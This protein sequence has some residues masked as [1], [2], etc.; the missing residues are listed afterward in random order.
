[1]I[2]IFK[3]DT[4]KDGTGLSELA[5]TAAIS[6]VLT[7]AMKGYITDSFQV[8]DVTETY[9]GLVREE[10]KVFVPTPDEE[11]LTT[12]TSDPTPTTVTPKASMTGVSDDVESVQV[13]PRVKTQEPA[14]PLSTPITATEG[15]K[16]NKA[17][18]G[19]RV[20]H[21]NGKTMD[22]I[23]EAVDGEKK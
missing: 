12:K 11:F 6:G 21:V 5:L 16:Q 14:K 1:M 18:D 15:G 22:K 20:V 7:D 19:E 23:K 9:R 8:I 10:K 2:K 13:I 17:K 4:G 3:I